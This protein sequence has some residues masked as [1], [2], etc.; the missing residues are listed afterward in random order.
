MTGTTLTDVLRG[1]ETRMKFVLVISLASIALLLVSLPSIE[2]G[3]TTHLLVYIQLSTFG[4]L[5]ATMLALLL[6]TVRAD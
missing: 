6:W 1:Y 4:V 3:T 2:P 5:A